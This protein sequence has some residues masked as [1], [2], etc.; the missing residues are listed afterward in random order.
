M[1]SSAARPSCGT[2][3]QLKI[4]DS[5]STRPQHRLIVLLIQD[6]GADQAVHQPSL[7]SEGG[8]LRRLQDPDPLLR[9]RR[10]RALLPLLQERPSKI[11]Q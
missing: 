1:K 2:R 8:S 6:Y 7:R 5:S 10:L 4:Q 9:R 11:I 3:R